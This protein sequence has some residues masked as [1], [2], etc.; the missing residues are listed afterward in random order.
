ML[1]LRNICYQTGNF[2]LNDINISVGQGEYF[3]LLG[4]SGAGKSVLLELIAGLTFADSGNIFFYNK[5]YTDSPAWKRPF[6]LVFQDLALFPHLNVYDN[7]A[8]S[9]KRKKLSR[10][11]IDKRVEE[12]SNELEIA[13]LLD[14][15]PDS[16]SGGEQQRVALART[17]ALKPSVLLLDEPLSAVDVS[18]QHELRALLRMINRGGVTIVHVTHSFEEALAMAQRV[19]I[20]EKGTIIHTG[21]THEV[22][23]RPKSSFI[24]NL[25]GHRNFF[26]VKVSQEKD[27]DLLKAEV[28]PGNF[29][30]CYGEPSITEGFVLINHEN[31]VLSMEKPELSTRNNFFGTITD[32]HPSRH[33]Y[34][35]TIETGIRL[36]AQITTE[37][38]QKFCLEPGSNIWACFKASSVTLID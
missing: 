6:G 7:I 36:H 12:L 13:H 23:D 10:K 38:V 4:P 15:K 1:E 17:L 8:Y 28:S 37:T 30:Y 3:V 11:I 34:E 32:L 35:V 5:D 26:K 24:A 21:T 22:F 19:S 27:S 2:E 25:S 33:G 31:I 20:I 14:R 29:I 9:L 18:L 16:L